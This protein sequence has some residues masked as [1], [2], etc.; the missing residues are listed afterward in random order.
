MYDILFPYGT[1]KQK[2]A[3][4]WLLGVTMPNPDVVYDNINT[5]HENE[6]CIKWFSLARYPQSPISSRPTLITGPVWKW[7]QTLTKR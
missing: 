7:A 2:T 6:V 3:E 5:V 1:Y 4:D